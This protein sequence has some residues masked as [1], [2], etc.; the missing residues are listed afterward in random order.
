MLAK[1][2]IGDVYLHGAS[3]GVVTNTTPLTLALNTGE[4]T[5]IEDPDPLILVATASQVIEQFSE[6][7][8]KNVKNR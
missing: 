3:V 2:H 1:L 4:D 6:G 8:I 7:I 5:I